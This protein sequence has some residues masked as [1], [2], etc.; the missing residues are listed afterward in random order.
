MNST[1]L[2][3]TYVARLTPGDSVVARQSGRSLT[4]QHAAVQTASAV[5]A[6]E[7]PTNEE[8]GAGHG[9]AHSS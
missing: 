8:K 5:A 7:G 6:Q 3:A 4:L 9:P 1:G 2:G